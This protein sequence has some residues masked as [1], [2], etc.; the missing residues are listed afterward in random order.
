MLMD[1]LS[2]AQDGV[3]ER[4]NSV[5]ETGHSITLAERAGDAPGGDGGAELIVAADTWRLLATMN[6]GGDFGKRELSP[7][8]RNRFTEVWVPALSDRDELR[9]LVAPRLAHDAA[10]T[11][12]ADA[13]AD[14]WCVG[15]FRLRALLC[16]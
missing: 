2:L 9:L 16:A 15:P 6:P 11:P 12:L 5:L 7:A 3:L 8:L 4:L 14:F 10:L 1:E 13:L